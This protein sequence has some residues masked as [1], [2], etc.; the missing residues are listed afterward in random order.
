MSKV[1]T[2][3]FGINA[4]HNVMYVEGQQWPSI[5]VRI[6]SGCPCMSAINCGCICMSGDQWL[7]QMYVGDQRWPHISSATVVANI[8]YVFSTIA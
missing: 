5:N 7:P 4:G 1:A 3:V 6:N 2:C 8:N